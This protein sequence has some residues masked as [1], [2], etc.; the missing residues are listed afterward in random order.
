MRRLIALGLTFSFCC[1]MALAAL[2]VVVRK[3]GAALPADVVLETDIVYG[4]GGAEDLKLDLTRPRQ[5]EG[6][7]PAIVFVHGGGWVG[8]SKEDF[9][10]F[11][12]PF[13][14]KG[15]VCI[16]VN[17]RLAPKSVFPAQIEDVKCGV[18]W[19]HA[20]AE[21]YHVDPKRIVAF[22]GS[23]GAHLV[24][25]LGTT[26]GTKL[27]DGSGGNAGQSSTI[28]AMVCM[29]GPYDL[30]LAYRDSVHQN[31][32]EGGAVRG[33]LEAFLGGNP[34]KR[35]SPYRDASPMTY[36][37]KQTVPALLTHGTADPLVP[38]EQ[39]EVFTAKLKSVGVEVEFMRIEGA[40]H[41]DF[42][43]K[44]EEQLN[45][46]IAFVQKQLLLPDKPQEHK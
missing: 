12:V 11:M 20:N 4:R 40:G 35:E 32:Q 43:P 7:F 31:K 39:T 25:L 26:N 44:P 37:S 14:Q 38:I 15:I 42:G 29:S 28:S 33:M 1:A 19:L 18:R 36:A 2:L 41:A 34:E 22:G 23:A 10:A 17:Y 30:S 3:Q 8:G 27:W 13:T 9:R 21:K 46:V 24:A 5:G 16:S 45:K 6:P